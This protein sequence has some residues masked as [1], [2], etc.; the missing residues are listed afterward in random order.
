MPGRVT[1]IRPGLIVGPRDGSDRFTYWPVRIARGGEVLAPGKPS[2][3]T[4]Y[5]DVRDLAGFMVHCLEQELADTYNVV[6]KPMPFGDMLDACMKTIDTDAEL[7]WVA[8]AFLAEQDLQAWRD[9]PAWADSDSALA[10]SLTWSADKALAAGLT[11]R[12]T[13]DTVRDTLAWFRSL[14]PDRQGTLRAGI[15]AEKE[16]AVLA[17]WHDSRGAGG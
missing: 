11:I 10:G 5:I 8:A 4:Q 16:A 7:T 15:S 9:I 14:P 17:A 13:E 12:P 3:Q 2:D 1:Q 6:R